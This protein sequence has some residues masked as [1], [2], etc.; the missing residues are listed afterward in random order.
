MAVMLHSSPSRSTIT[1]GIREIESGASAELPPDR[2]RRP[3]GGRK[4]VTQK[5]PTL[6]ED[7]NALVEPTAS[8]DPDSPLRWTSKS[9][10]KLAGELEGMGHEASHRLVGELLKE[11]GY[12]LQANRK[13][14]EGPGC[15]RRGSSSP[16]SR[17]RLA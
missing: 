6:L 4:R 13:T 11:N 10:R 12:S 8:G 14:R 17:S 15:S 7:L 2:T 5:D 3:G 9:L 1:R 16:R